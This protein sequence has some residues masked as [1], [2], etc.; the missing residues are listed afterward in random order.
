VR[1]CFVTLPAVYISLENCQSN[2]K[3][4][5]LQIWFWTSFNF[6]S[7]LFRYNI[8]SGIILSVF[9]ISLLS[10]I[11]LVVHPGST[12]FYYGSYIQNL[13]QGCY[14]DK[15]SL[16]KIVSCKWDWTSIKKEE[17]RQYL[18]VFYVL[19]WISQCNNDSLFLYTIW[20]STTYIII[21]YF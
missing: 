2:K 6:F 11:N 3:D 18:P 16:F 10:V 21:F 4:H 17:G 19:S 13:V 7:Y 15:L 20:N 9:V 5:G 1:V 12:C 8:F 14:F